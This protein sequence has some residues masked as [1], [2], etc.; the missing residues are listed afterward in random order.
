[1]TEPAKLS[2]AQLDA[3]IEASN[4]EKVK[5]NQ[6]GA[7]KNFDIAKKALEA[8]AKH[9]TDAQKAEIR[10]FVASKAG[11]KPKAEGETAKPKKSK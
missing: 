5:R 1:M 11:R 3:L 4:A 2:D 8:S 7:T 9:F 10:A 6:A